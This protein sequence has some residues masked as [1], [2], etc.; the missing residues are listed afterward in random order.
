[1]VGEED[2]EALS[3]RLRPMSAPLSI[4]E[5]LDLVASTDGITI[6]KS[7]LSWKVA[8]LVV[9]AVIWDGFLVF[10]YS[11]VL[12]KPNP[13]LMAVFFPLGHVAVG[14]GLT[15]YIVASTMN[16]T[17]VVISPTVVRVYHG[18]APWPGNQALRIEEITDVV[19]RER[20]GNRGARTFSVMYVDRARKER[21]LVTGFSESDQV[22]YIAAMVRDTLGLVT[23]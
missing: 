6:R 19:I 10:W 3:V 8:P 4:P 21:K 17:E 5:G 20:S 11:Q 1:V 9:F 22:E 18:P 7:W 2:E 13:P 16:R 12:S 14:L 15:Y 23:K